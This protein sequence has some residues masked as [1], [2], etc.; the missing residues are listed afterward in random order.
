MTTISFVR[1]DHRNTIRVSAHNHT[2]SIVCNAVS[3]MMYSLESWLINHSDYVKS[4]ESEFKSGDA[5]I[6][7]VPRKSEIYI[8]L[9]FIYEGLLDLEYSYGKELVSISCDDTLKMLMG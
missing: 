1:D 4:H 9:A 5:Y 8:I 7:F 6:E 3:M 2:Q